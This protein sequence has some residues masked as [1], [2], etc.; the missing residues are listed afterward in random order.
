LTNNQYGTSVVFLA[1]AIHVAATLTLKNIPDEV[2]ARPKGS[3]VAHRR[4]MN[5]EAILCLEKALLPARVDPAERL[6]RA[7]QLRNAL[8]VGCFHADDIV[9]LKRAGRE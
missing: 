5:S 1:E 7:R 8:S 9:V 3:A 4:S 2:Y 6:P